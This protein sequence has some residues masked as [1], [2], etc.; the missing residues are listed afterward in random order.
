MPATYVGMRPGRT[1]QGGPGQDRLEKSGGLAPKPRV[2]SWALILSMLV[3][4]VGV[5]AAPA[6]AAVVNFPDPSLEQAI[7]DGNS[8]M[9]R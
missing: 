2:V 4:P 9:R 1:T 6:A 8:D 3:L 7:R 5:S